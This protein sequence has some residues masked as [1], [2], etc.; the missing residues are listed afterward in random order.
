MRQI[1]VTGGAGYLGSHVVEKLL[2]RG[3]KVRIL[4]N[5]SF[6]DKALKLL[7]KKYNFELINGDIRD[8]RIILQSME[9]IDA[10]IHL[11]GIV[12]DPASKIDPVKSTEVNYLSTKLVVDTAKYFKIKQ[13]IFASSCSVYGASN[14]HILNE[15]SK[16][17]PL[18]IYA[19]TKLKSEKV[20]LD[21]N[22]K[23]FSP[24]I[25][26]AG[27]FFGYSNRMRFDLVVNLFVG[28]A[29]SKHKIV[30]EGGDQWR[31]FI[32][33]V[34]A[35]DAYVLA[36]EKTRSKMKGIFN[37][38]ADELNHQLKEI[39]KFVK[40]SIPDVRVEQSNNTDRRNYRVSFAK[41]KK[42]LG[43]RAE[44]SVTDGI[45]EIKNAIVSGKIRSWENPI[46]YNN[47]F[48][49]TGKNKTSKY[50]WK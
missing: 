8:L 25:F 45:A 39:A 13:F 21:S 9:G 41:I 33:V 2:N 10:V 28:Q 16:L 19:E 22:G 7:K 15:S 32:H 20:L 46:Y 42:T 30:V 4:D 48:P 18:S 50:Y 31:P 40:S 23:D 47:R 12:G 36:L 27:T 43:F 29:I 5:L 34:D 3:Y 24:T 38:G 35:A 11:A 17:N 49:L 26:R 6:G 37:L 1:L 44:K 14:S